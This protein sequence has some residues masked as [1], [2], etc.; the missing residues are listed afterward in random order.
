MLLIMIFFLLPVR[1]LNDAT[2]LVMLA[3]HMLFLYEEVAY[4]K[5][6]HVSSSRQ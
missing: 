1:L 3:V 2:K 6:R 4:Y 5:P